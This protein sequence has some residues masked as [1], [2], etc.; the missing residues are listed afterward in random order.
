MITLITAVPGGGKTALAVSMMLDEGKGRPIFQMGIPELKIDHQPVPPVEEWTRLETTP[1]DKTQTRAVF[2][3]P[4]NSIIVID[5]AQNVYRPRPTGS[6]VPDYVKAFE[7]HRHL[8]IDFWIITQSPGLIDSNVRKLVGRHIHLRVTALG[9]FLYEGPECFDVES[10]SAR[11]ICAK[12]RYR[13]PKHVYS[14]YKSSSLHLK[15]KHRLPPQVYVLASVVIV[16][17]VIF[18]YMN[19]RYH[20][21]V[22]PSNIEKTVGSVAGP[23]QEGARPSRPVFSYIES[24]SPSVPGLAYTAPRYA[25]VTKPVRAPV[26][27]ACVQ[28][29]TECRCYTDQATRL[30]V[31]HDLCVQIVKNGFYQDF[32]A[33]PQKAKQVGVTGQSPIR[34]YAVPASAISNAPES[35]RLDLP[36]SETNPREVVSRRISG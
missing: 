2:T 12:R 26:P 22:S 27:S 18:W 31:P 1:E 29:S 6:K 14:L 16:F 19:K 24:M 36:D 34:S 5:E 3:F 33:D 13:L 7:T 25:D 15:V 30:N 4:E 23:T 32:D 21:V 11:D 8:G 35:V 9:R 28:S 17:A 20:Q 10:K